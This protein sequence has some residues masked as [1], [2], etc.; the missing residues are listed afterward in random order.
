MKVYFDNVDFR[1]SSGPNSFVRRL[2]K[3]LSVMGVEIADSDDYDV[4]LVTIEPT[5]RLDVS[6]PFVQR[7]DGIWFKP[8]E[9]HTHNTR[10]KD[11]YD[12]ATSVVFQS[13]FDATMIQR[14]FGQ[15]Q[16]SYTVPNGIEIK[17][18]TQFAD[19][20]L[21]IR[22]EYETIFVCS[23]SW[24]PQKRLDDNIRLY[25]QLRK[26]CPNSCLIVMGGGNVTMDPDSVK[27]RI[28][29][30]GPQPQEV[31]LQVFAAADWMIHLAWLDHC[32]NTVLESLSQE[33]PVICGDSGGTHELIVNRGSI[34]LNDRRIS[35]NGIVLND[36]K[37]NYE[38]MDYDRPPSFPILDDLRLDLSKQKVDIDHLS[39][40]RCALRYKR[41]LQSACQ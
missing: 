14:W 38:L 22:Q 6:K 24:H 15:R 8:E 17:R 39:I 36:V 20:I 23:A 32:P 5:S 34:L 1:S 13:D 18:V 40:E 41:I 25:K 4:A 7:L 30:T 35:N 33:T 3:Q 26:Q 9:F 27:D 21:K 31:C 2:A 12:H 11:C 37:Y 19:A 29:Y 16:Y 10:I 28:F